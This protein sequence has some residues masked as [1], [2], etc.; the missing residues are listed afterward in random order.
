MLM[1]RPET[2]AAAPP[3]RMRTAS[4][5]R[6]L[7]MAL[8]LLGPALAVA[9]YAWALASPQYAAEAAFM[10]RG[11]EEAAGARMGLLGLGGAS[12]A[13]MMDGF[14]VVEFIGSRDALD[15][16]RARVD[17]DA[18]MAKAGAD[19]L[20]RFDRVRDGDDDLAY[21]RAMVQADFSITK[22]IV[23]LRVHAFE[24]ADADAIGL[25][26]LEIVEDFANVMN[27]RAREDMLRAAQ[28]EVEAAAAALQERQAEIQ[29]WRLANNNIDPERST[30]M[31]LQSIAHVEEALIEARIDLARLNSLADPGARG[32]DLQTRIDILT[33]E[34]AAQQ[35]RLTGSRDDS[36]AR[37]A[38]EFERL[39][40][41]REI[42]QQLYANAVEAL[43]EARAEANRQQKFI[44]P[45]KSPYA[46]ASPDWPNAP[47]MIALTFLGSL[48]AWLIGRFLHDAATDGFH[49]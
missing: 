32:R 31:V 37:Q 3:R 23:M 38:M 35:A 19:P 42:G 11:R 14:A 6:R 46:D 25:A 29:A 30:E 26:L 4:P 45:V 13:M 24:A 9:I 28:G 49:G 7:L 18:M 21:Y 40:L 10:I 5:L 33:A 27:E 36:A 17:Y 22:Q 47:K 39:R 48:F 41:A 12:P 8:V 34:L 15:R 1:T 43:S 16:L 44:V 20:A 2:A